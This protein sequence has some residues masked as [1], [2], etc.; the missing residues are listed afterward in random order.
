MTS[1]DISRIQALVQAQLEQAQPSPEPPHYSAYHRAAAVLT[2]YD[3]ETLRP[4]GKTTGES[5]NPLLDDS[6]VATDMHGKVRWTLT[7]RVRRAVLRQMGSRPT[8]QRALAANSDRPDDPTQQMLEGYIFGDAPPIEQQNTEQLTATYRVLEWLEGVIDGLPNRQQVQQQLD[9]M[10]LMQPFYD[11]VGQHFAGRERELKIL[12]EYVGVLKAGSRKPSRSK[13]IIDL[14]QKLPLVIS[15]PGGTGKSA[16]LARFICEHV[17]LP[18]ADRFPWTYIDFDRPSI[19]AEEPISLLVEAVWQLGIQYPAARPA[20]DRVRDDWQPKRDRILERAQVMQSSIPDREDEE[21]LAPLTG[22]EDWQRFM[23]DFASLLGNLKLVSDPFLFVLD[24]FEEVQYRSDA[25]VSRVLLFLR[26]LQ[27]YVPHLRT[28]LVGRAPLPPSDIFPTHNITL[29]DFDRK[30][31]QGFLEAHGFAPTEAAA[32]I[33]E[34]FGGNPLTLKLAVEVWRSDP[35]DL[36]SLRVRRNQVQ[37]QL[38]ARIL[39]HIHTAPV[40]QL[41]Y[42]GLILRRVTPDLIREVLAAPCGVKVSDDA[43]AQRL[44]TELRREVSL[45]TDEGGALRHRPDVR[46]IMIRLLREQEPHKI[47]V[48]EKAA[49]QYYEQ[50]TEIVDRAEEIYHR[51]S[52]HQ[53][54]G[55][56]ERRWDRRVRPYLASA[57]D[58]LDV[59]ERVWLLRKLGRKIGEEDRKQADLASWEWDTEREATDL[60][61]AR[62]YPRALERL[63]EREARMP[64]SRLFLLEARAL[65]GVA[66]WDDQLRMVERGVTSAS[67]G[68]APRLAVDLLVLGAR[69]HIRRADYVAARRMLDQAT[70]L[71]ADDGDAAQPIEIRLHRLALSQQIIADAM[72]SEEDKAAA[73]EA[74]PDIKA[75]LRQS[76]DQLMDDEIT[77]QSALMGWLARELGEEYPDVLAK[78][79]ERTGILTEQQPLLRQLGRAIDTWDRELSEDRIESVLARTVGVLVGDIRPNWQQLVLE[80]ESTQQLGV[81]VAA[82]LRSETTINQQVLRI[83]AAVLAERARDIAIPLVVDDGAGI[84]TEQLPGQ[85]DATSPAVSPLTEAHSPG[86]R[87]RRRLSGQLLA[88]IR[89]AFL[90][91][92]T[93]SEFDAMLIERMDRSRSAITIR[94]NFRDIVFDVVRYADRQG[95]LNQLILSARETRPGDPVLYD[96]A[97]QFGLTATVDVGQDLERIIR[98]SE[99]FLDIFTWRKRLA[100]V[101]NHVCRVEVGAGGGMGGFGTGFLLGPDL[102]MTT[103][104]VLQQIIEGVVKPQDVHF[105]FDY[106]MVENSV[107]NAG[108]LY[109]LAHDWL[110]DYSPYSQADLEPNNGLP[111]FDELDYVLMRLAGEPGREPVGGGRVERDAVERGWIEVQ[112]RPSILRVG[113][114]L[115]ILQHPAGG[116]LKLTLDNQALVGL[117]ENRTRVYYR[118]N[119]EPGSAGSPC[120][121]ENWNLVAMHH[122]SDPNFKPQYNQGIPVDAILALLEQRGKRGILGG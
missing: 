28:V 98:R 116:P 79:I 46:Q 59:R 33:A 7:S 121:D 108:T 89:D 53:S 99:P 15:A 2:S 101:E 67:E 47:C 117:N 8:L 10:R 72:A 39:K 92:F 109:G 56:I 3:D 17:T 29:G 85:P 5:I 34:R 106:M 95:W 41:A 77:R 83:L 31:A 75:A 30:A 14:H 23:V 66:S 58:E 68:G 73:A 110:V 118:T 76:F 97:T 20:C 25:I 32:T 65:E 52:L 90:A 57:P 12:R 54:F 80:A 96:I 51:L 103:Y 13:A 43:T 48:I 70:D 122:A 4:D 107:V 115:F 38:F 50:R 100:S 42:P 87:S 16:L 93:L 91:A 44:F 86:S 26:T 6:V 88:R 45:V 36:L 84:N 102:L 40:R 69:A 78:I 21:P 82:L 24:T 11:L 55:E 37:G 49:V 112:A 94:P 113:M 119:T 64:G 74:I 9:L 27:Q 35:G 62:Q 61:A 111:N 60:L 18:K 114:P 81:L 1:I 22:P 19:Q 104:R 120:F 63:A 71:L 105:R